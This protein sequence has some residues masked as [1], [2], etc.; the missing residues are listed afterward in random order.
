VRLSDVRFNDD[1]AFKSGADCVGALLAKTKMALIVRKN[2]TI[3]TYVS[4]RNPHT[5]TYTH[6]I[7]KLFIA[8]LN[9]IFALLCHWAV[10]ENSN[11]MP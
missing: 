4:L 2:E 6:T 10:I 7:K 8:L 1:V 9:V 11:I 3:K 5:P